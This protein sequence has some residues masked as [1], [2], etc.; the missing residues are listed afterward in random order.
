MP[1]PTPPDPSDV[2]LVHRLA[3]P[4]LVLLGIELLLGVALNLFV[5]LP[6]TG[7]VVS[8]LS[9]SWVLDLHILD[10]ALI[11]GISARLLLVAL[12]TPSGRLQGASAL[13]LLA[14][15]LAVAGGWDFVFHGQ[16]PAASGVM[17]LGF[18]LVLVAAILLRVWSSGGPSPTVAP[19]PGTA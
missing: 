1:E 13:A 4:L 7:T 2:A 6:M 11:V 12:R 8:I 18:V 10:A 9:S 17:T 16:S 5:N 14:A 3:V 19:V 15:L